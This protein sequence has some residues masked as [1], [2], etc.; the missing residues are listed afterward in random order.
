MNFSKTRYETMPYNRVG[1][2]GL[3]LPAISLGM[4]HNF[5]AEDPFENQT[6]MLRTAFDLGITHFDLADNYGGG[7]AEV[8]VGNILKTEFKEH[9]DELIISSKAGHAMW[10]G[11]YGDW[12]SRKHL[13]SGID[14][15]LKR[16]QLEYV[17][18]FYHHRPDSETPAE[19]TAAALADIVR[20][21][22]AL[23]IGISN[24]YGEP[25]REMIQCLE[26]EGTPC[27]INQLPFNMFDR[28][29]EE[30][31]EFQGL[32]KEGVGAITFCP[33]AQ[34]LL[35]GRYL[36]GIP[37]DSRAATEGTCLDKER[38]EPALLDKVRALNG[39]AEARGQT[40]AQMALCWN[41]TFK[42]V[43]SVLIGAS[44]P[45]QISENV[46][47]L[48]SAGFSEEERAQIAAVISR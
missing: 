42:P 45:S 38:I 6:E 25:S 24:Y 7:F 21:G 31:G 15:S 4:W 12:G 1:R 5:G 17:D 10:D 35:S 46:Q 48:S 26:R 47:A 9:R 22:K 40:L 37:A 3:K 34:G 28:N 36:N 19:E 14:Q 43:A 30:S 13:I 11:P 16:L 29:A 39:L 27:L 41:L 44:R 32:E 18:I 2:S 23:Y 20:Q 33:L 8:N